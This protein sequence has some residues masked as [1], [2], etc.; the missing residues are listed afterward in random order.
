MN[1]GVASKISSVGSDPIWTSPSAT[2]SAAPELAVTSASPTWPSPR[3]SAT[4]TPRTSVG[5]TRSMLPRE[6]AK[7]I[8]VPG[9]TGEPSA[10]RAMTVTSDKPNRSITPGSALMD[11]VASAGAT[12]V[13]LSHAVAT[14]SKPATM[15]RA[16]R[17]RFIVPEFS[18]RTKAAARLDSRLPSTGKLSASG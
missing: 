13:G 6:V 2:I 12:G 5:T 1:C 3:S 4:A 10:L 7:N 15:E 9:F 18:I 8:S 11:R 16:I 17:I 14:A